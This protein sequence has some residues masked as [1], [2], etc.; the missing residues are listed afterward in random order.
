MRIRRPLCKDSRTTS[1][2]EALSPRVQASEG[3]WVR[4]LW[5]GKVSLGR[6]P[7]GEGRSALRKGREGKQCGSTKAGGGKRWEGT[8]QDG[9]STL[10]P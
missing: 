9:H 1:H 2:T 8:E 3:L 10:A 7:E 4:K 5:V 6:L